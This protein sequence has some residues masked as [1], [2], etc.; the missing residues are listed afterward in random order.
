MKTLNLRLAILA[1]V[2]LA[3]PFACTGPRGEGWT[4]T[5]IADG[6]MYYTFSGIDK[7]SGSAQ[8]VF[9][10]DQDLNNPKYEPIW[11]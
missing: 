9:V 8:Q 7:V 10:I 1:I 11:P 2:L 4:T 5:K 6:I 3:L